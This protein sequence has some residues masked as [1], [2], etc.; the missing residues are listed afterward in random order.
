M[1]SEKWFLSEVESCLCLLSLVEILVWMDTCI[2]MELGW[3]N[4][5]THFT[6]QI[7]HSLILVTLWMKDCY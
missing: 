7:L 6:R 3:M 1:I 4:L 5:I 2:L